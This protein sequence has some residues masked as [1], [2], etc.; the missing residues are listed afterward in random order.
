MPDSIIDDGTET[1]VSTTTASSGTSMETS[2]HF[3]RGDHVY[4][5]CCFAGIPRVFQ[6][7]GIVMH[8]EA[9]EDGSEQLTIADFSNFLPDS[10]NNRKETKEQSEEEA[11]TAVEDDESTTSTTKKRKLWSSRKSKEK[12]EQSSASLVGGGSSTGGILR[13]YTTTSNSAPWHKVEYNA[14]RWKTVLNR[15]GISTTVAAS[16][17][18]E[19]VLS[20]VNFLIMQSERHDKNTFRSSVL[21]KYHVIFA[22]CE[23]VAMWCKTGRW[24][25]LQGA[26]LLTGVTYGSTTMA[27]GRAGAGAAAV[28][29]SA[30]EVAAVSEGVM[31]V[32]SGPSITSLAGFQPWM[33]TA[34]T[35]YLGGC[36]ATL[37]LARSRW[38]TTTKQ[39]NEA[40]TTEM[41]DS[42]VV[43]S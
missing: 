34:M 10:G 37:L 24:S 32:V 42:I 18:P 40:L 7:H 38:N 16:D 17:S 14:P 33:L 19:V 43:P 31:G 22:N 26:S 29:G 9:L 23:C 27:L 1:T 25:T 12:A 36:T 5:W 11:E 6:H 13:V 3:E 39:L 2:T 4:Q 28:V 35:A 30:A 21:P 41:A 15:S 20:R 8:V